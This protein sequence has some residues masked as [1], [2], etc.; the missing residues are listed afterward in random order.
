MDKEFTKF[1]SHF[2]ALDEEIKSK[3]R[4]GLNTWIIKPG[5]NTNRGSGIQ[6]VTSLDEIKRIIGKKV[7]I[8]SS[9]NARSYIIQKYLDNPF[10]YNKRKFDIR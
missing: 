6:Y 1:E 5:E 8:P 10:L 4:K 9:G 3:N 7:F 2:K